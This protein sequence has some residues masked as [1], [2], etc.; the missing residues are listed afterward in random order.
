MVRKK[1]PSINSRHGEDTRNI[2]NATIDSVNDLLDKLTNLVVEGKLSDSQFTSILNNLHRGSP[3]GVFATLNALNSAYPNGDDN[4]Y[5]VSSNNNWYY[6]DGTWKAGGEYTNMDAISEIERKLKEHAKL[7]GEV[8]F[9]NKITSIDYEIDWSSNGSDTVKNGNVAINT[10]TG[11]SADPNIQIGYNHRFVAKPG[12]KIYVSALFKTT[13]QNKPRLRLSLQIDGSLAHV[14]EVVESQSGKEYLISGVHNIPS[15][16]SG[17]SISTLLFHGYTSSAI[18]EGQQTEFSHVNVFNLTEIFGKGKEPEIEK[19][20]DALKHLPNFW[21]ESNETIYLTP[22]R[23]EGGGIETQ[24]MNIF[25][26]VKVDGDSEVIPIKGMTHAI[27]DINKASRGDLTLKVS[28]DQSSW[29]A[30]NLFSMTTHNIFQKAYTEGRFLTDVTGWEYIKV[31][32]A[33]RNTGSFTVDIITT[34]VKPDIYPTD[35]VT[36]DNRKPSPLKPITKLVKSKN[37]GQ[38]M[39][40]R[41]LPEGVFYGNAGA[42][43]R[44]STDGGDTWFTLN[45]S[46]FPAGV[47][48]VWK[49]EPGHILAFLSNGKTYSYN[50]DTK[51]S[52]LVHTMESS[53]A[54]LSATLGDLCVYENIVLMS[55]YGP[56]NAPDNGRRAYLSR[57]YGLTW[58]KIFEGFLASERPIKTWHIHG[59]TYDPYDNIIWIVNGDSYINA[60][61]WYSTDWGKSWAKVWEDG[62]SNTQFTTVYPLPN[63]VLF[64]SD[65]HQ[66]SVWRWDRPKQGI[67]SVDKVQLEMA[68]EIHNNFNGIEAIATSSA[69]TFGDKPALYFSYQFQRDDYNG[70]PAIIYATSDGYNFYQIWES[71]VSP[72]DNANN[73]LG[74]TGITGPSVDGYLVAGYTHRY[75]GNTGASNFLKIKEPDWINI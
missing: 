1:L 68:Y 61:V 70:E 75:P 53:D 9:V 5:V 74:I 8:T 67:S 4:I 26:D 15:N 73:Y 24:R 25:N 13:S 49:T 36:S 31:S 48:R 45:D 37:S 21:V 40:A 35:L 44:K 6:Y 57:D 32:L 38:A 62:F 60:N 59:I 29:T 18:A 47:Q 34:N 41:Y 11:L 58:E 16:Y 2:I 3:K 17:G 71:D 39:T 43:I 19:V 14:G 42:Y 50:E 69:V 23:S 63:C 65:N 33:L 20:E 52:T 30:L 10:A 22:K 12:D 7:L 56:N 46:A 27:L 55:E 51:I 64:G 54:N 72:T 66:T 28:N